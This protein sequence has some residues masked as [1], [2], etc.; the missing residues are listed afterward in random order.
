VIGGALGALGASAAETDLE[1][2]AIPGACLVHVKTA[3][4]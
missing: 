3:R 4:R 1:P 2:F